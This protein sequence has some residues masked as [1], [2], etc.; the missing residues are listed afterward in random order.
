VSGDG[1]GSPGGGVRLRDISPRLALQAHVVPT[2]VKVE[3]VDRLTEAGIGAVEV[4][5]FVRPD[6]VPG[7]AD[8]AEVFA[9]V[10]RPEGV[11]LECCVANE[12]GLRRAIDAGADAAWFLLSADESFSLANTGRSIEGSLGML[13]RL[14]E[15][16]AQS[17]T[18]LGSYLIAAW[19]GPVGPPRGPSELTPMLRR[20]ADLG[21]TEWILADSCGYASPRQAV[22]LAA[23]AAKL[24][25]IEELAV[26]VHDSRGMGLADLAA[27]ADL[28]VRRLDTALAGTGAHPAAPDAQ[29]GGVCT[30]DAAQMLELMG[31][32]TGTNLQAL[33]DA[34]NWLAAILGET[35]KGFTRSAG[36]LTPTG[37]RN[38]PSSFAWQQETH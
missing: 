4:S 16:A 23:A 25:P 35:A 12:T 34:A 31:H 37:V 33:T 11:S 21:V 15:L 1:G 24:V 29:V 26:Q 38:P 32:P 7:L 30:E 3:L 13:S 18:R 6:L 5:S 36:I 28:G 22:E 9:R 19:G 20:L 14:A 8:A 17:R 10:R 27:L 2:E